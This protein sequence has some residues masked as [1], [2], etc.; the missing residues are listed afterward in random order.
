MANTL[1][2]LAPLLFSAARIVPKELTGLL[3]A[4]D[5]NFDDKGVAAGQTVTVPVMPTLSIGN[6]TAAQTFTAGTS[7]TAGS[8]TLTLNNQK[9]VSWNYTAEEERSLANGGNQADVFRQTVEQG[10]RVIRNTIESH[11]WLKARANSS[12]GFG[13]AAT[14]PFQTTMLALTGV[15]KILQ[16]NGMYLSGDMS[17]CIDTNAGMNLR[18]LSNLFKVNEA[19]SDMLKTG[20]LGSLYGYDIR[21][22]AAITTT[23]IGTGTSY[24]SDTAGHAVGTTDIPIIT[25]SGTVLAGDLVTF[26]GDTNK[27]TVVTG[28][29]APG[30]ITI[31]EPGLKIALAAS[32]VNMT[33]GS[34]GTSHIACRNKAVKAVIR[35]ALQPQGGASESMVVTDPE[36]GFS[37]L[38]TR[39]VGKLMTSYYMNVVYD[40]FVPNREGVAQLIG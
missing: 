40:S 27:Y 12:R 37:F 9:E 31:A 5:L 29:S 7:L 38:M 28:V 24:T 4:S 21:E 6:T 35:P 10:I 3:G 33:I 30:T 20:V 19:G 34:I 25:G 23:A 13:T 2:A 11:L 8:A 18:N 17:L 26:T 16:D 1:T 14:V 32:A 36:T 22:S 39:A 15:S